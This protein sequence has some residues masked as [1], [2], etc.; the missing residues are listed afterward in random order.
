MLF[1]G[2]SFII[3]SNTLVNSCIC[4]LVI[5]GITMQNISSFY[6]YFDESF[7]NYSLRRTR[8]GIKLG[9]INSAK[10]FLKITYVKKYYC[11]ASDEISKALIVFILFSSDN[12]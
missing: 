5:Y 11:K 4:Y 10:N 7:F 1:A 12:I 3:H 9:P 6:S 2:G 8:K